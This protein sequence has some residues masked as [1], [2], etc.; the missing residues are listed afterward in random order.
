VSI[1]G[2]VPGEGGIVVT[3]IGRACAYCEQPAQDP[4]VA[5]SGPDGVLVVHAHCLGPW[6]IRMARD[7]H[8]IENPAFYTR[9][10]RKGP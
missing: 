2:P 6:F 4:A 10:R 8:E 9:R 1:T 3:A 7:A 5:W